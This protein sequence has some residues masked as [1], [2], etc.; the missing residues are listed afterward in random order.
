M[1]ETLMAL[2]AILALSGFSA[3][4]FTNYLANPGF[5]LGTNRWVIVQPWSWNG[6]SYA[7]QNTNQLINGS[8]TAYVSV[9]GGT[10]A[11]KEWGYYQT[12]AVASGAMQTFA[13]APGSTWTAD[14]W[15]STQAPDN[16]GTNGNGVSSTSYLQV[17]F[18]NAATN[19]NAPLAT[20]K[21]PSIDNSSAT[22]TWFYR[23]VVDSGNTTLTAPAGTAFVR[24]E[25]LVGQPAP[26][27]A[28]TPSNPYVYAGG[29]AYWD[30]VTLLK[31]SAPDP[32]ITV[33]PSPVTLVYGQTATF[34]VSAGGQTTLSYKWQ[35]DSADI[36]DPHAYG[37]NTATLTLSNV[38]TAMQGGYT[39]TVTDQ[40]GPLTSDPAQLTVND[41]GVL[42]ITP[43]LGQTT[44]NGGTAN[45]KVSAAGST[46]LTY[47]W[48]LN[49]NQLSD[50]GRISGTTTSN[51][52]VANLTAADA[53]TYTVSIDG[54]AIQASSGLKVVS[55]AQLAT[56]LV[57]N[58]GFEDGVFSEPWES[59]W[60]KF[61]G[62]AIDTLGNSW[63]GTSIT[64]VS[65][66]DGTNVCNTYGSDADNGLYENVA[67]IIAG[68]TYRAGGMFYVSSL[69]PVAGTTTITLQLMFKDAGGN[70][71][72]T[73]TAPVIDTSFVQDTWTNLYVTNATG[74]SNIVAPA[75]TVSATFQIYEFNWA[76]AG[77]AAYFDD[78]YLSQAALPL[79]AAVT[80]TPS[81]VSGVMHLTFPTASGVTYEVL[82]ANSLNSP[83]TWHTNSTIAGDGTPKTATD[84]IG[85]TQRFYRVMAHH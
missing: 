53:G 31:T 50:N 70:T 76:Y 55:P 6:P 42:S 73:L 14:G 72:T 77:G 15:V 27:G 37:V 79:P 28:G 7:V 46:A 39:C 84:P 8:Q 38:T 22:G 25:M 21:S 18:L 52:T 32:E 19:I 60:I 44:T 58:P 56:N 66:W 69:A 64:P 40:A 35:K 20:Y 29:S 45:I 47:S 71:L 49:N 51:L 1:L 23:Q 80:V 74:G 62:A 4:A 5:E 68:A 9:H 30:D 24:F 59:G 81:A 36:T 13:A 61:N 12:Y 3:R 48:Y 82:Y 16:L 78:L 75:G 43:P 34:S 83:I 10:N 33:Q 17:L 67:G 85:T 57:I 11:F 41:P 63:Y 26:S 54:G 65:I 2:T